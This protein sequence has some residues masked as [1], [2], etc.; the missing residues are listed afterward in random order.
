MTIK[1]QYGVASGDPGPHDVVLWTHVSES[2]GEVS[3]TVAADEGMADVVREGAVAI[4]RGADGC[5]KVDVSGLEPG[6][7]YF[8]R[9][10]LDGEP[11][12]I[13]RT[14]TLPSTGRLRIAI[15]SCAKYTAG[16]FN[17]YGRI[18][19]Q[20][21]DL[22]LH[23]GDY[24]YQG[25]IDPRDPGP[26]IE[27]A[28]EPPHPSV[29]LEDFR[30]RYAH[31]RSDPQLQELHRRHPLIAIPDDNDICNGTHRSGAEQHGPDHGLW[32]DRRKAALR[33]WRE[34][35]PVRLEDDAPLYRTFELGDLA[36]LFVV[37]ERSHRDPMTKGPEMDDANRSMLGSEQRDW[38]IHG[39][40][41]SK[42]LWKIVANPV[43]MGRCYS[44]LMPADVGH[45]LGE[46]G[47]IT[48]REHGPD[49]DQWDG[50]PAERESLLR[51]FTDAKTN[52]LV[53]VSGDVHS[54]WV[55]ELRPDEGQ[56]TAGPTAVEF[57]TPS[58]TSQNLNE[59]L[60][61]APEASAS[62]ES[63]LRQWNPHVKWVELTSHGYI[64]LEITEETVRAEW[65]FV[66]TVMTP[67]SAETV[68]AAWE[69]GRDGGELKR[70]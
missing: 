65:H 42:A 14:R 54:S 22:V 51:A 31:Y 25:G 4:D 44:E 63:W 39:V 60:A 43:M 64:V 70:T 9:F 67:S 16:F 69:V 47:V 23:L 52:G 2:N 30:F 5:V 15:V 11:S 12:P 50:Y 21:F 36:E 7:T 66:D 57:V 37:D 49:P 38:L 61:S 20:D 58:V 34:W 24:T 18:A 68:G 28:L 3:W 59:R 17:A 33:T 46:L 45:P 55:V 10:D 53:L 6:T 13:G 40:T 8:Y 26:Q 48:K 62:V 32:D 1:F 41:A 19:A 29:T 27:R 56:P 35:M